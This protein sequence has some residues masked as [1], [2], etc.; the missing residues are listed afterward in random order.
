[1]NRGRW[2]W[3]APALALVAV[4]AAERLQLTVDQ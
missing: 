3:I 4:L 1:M 2:R